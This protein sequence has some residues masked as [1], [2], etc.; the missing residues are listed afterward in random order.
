MGSIPLQEPTSGLS[1]PLST[2]PPSL[3]AWTF[4]WSDRV[5]NVKLTPFGTLDVSSITVK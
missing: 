4:G 1:R 2:A 5:A 3:M